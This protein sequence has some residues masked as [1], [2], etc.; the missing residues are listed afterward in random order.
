MSS[1]EFNLKCE[2]LEEF[3]GDMNGFTREEKQHYEFW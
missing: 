3:K 1:S 2:E